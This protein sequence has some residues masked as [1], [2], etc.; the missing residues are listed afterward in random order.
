MREKESKL[1]FSA[2]LENK[3]NLLNILENIGDKIVICKIHYDFYEDDNK[4]LK[5]KL[6]ELS[7]NKDFL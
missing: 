3:D 2:D 6:I 4:E 7:I 5:N 1:C